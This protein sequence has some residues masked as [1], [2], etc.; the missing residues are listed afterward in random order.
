M[1][2]KIRSFEKLM[3]LMMIYEFRRMK[4]NNFFKYKKLGLVWNKNLMFCDVFD[5]LLD[6]LHGSRMLKINLYVL[7]VCALYK[8][9]FLQKIFFSNCK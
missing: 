6:L 7:C 2:H 1:S 4:Q 3:K 8:S 9:Q 5:A